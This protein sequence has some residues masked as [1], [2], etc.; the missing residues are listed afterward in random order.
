MF[1]FI[2]DFTE[3]FM[4]ER[5][6]G[7]YFVKKTNMYY[8]EPIY[9]ELG[10]LDTF[11][12]VTIPSVNYKNWRA[13]LDIKTCIECRSKHGQIFQ[14]NEAVVPEPPLHYNCRCEIITLRSIKAG[15]ATKNKEDGADYWLKYFGELP[16]YYVAKNEAKTIGWRQGKLPANYIPGK[17]I[18]GGMYHNKNGHLPVAPG[19]IWYEADINYYDGKRNSHRILWS[20]DGLIF[21]TYDHYLIFYE[22]I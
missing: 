20:N 11:D 16:E 21:V 22:I 12:P 7:K 4:T 10:L 13:I 2:F 1:V 15:D 18:M 5:T 8:D 9:I 14:I 3:E 19:R 17:M 6:L